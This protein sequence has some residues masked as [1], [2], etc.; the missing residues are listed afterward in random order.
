MTDGKTTPA[1]AREV[2]LEQAALAYAAA[3]KAVDGYAGEK[4]GP[5]YAEL[6]ATW[7]AATLEL[8]QASVRL[9][10]AKERGKTNAAIQPA[11]TG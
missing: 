1:T 11:K 8:D 6:I 9:S 4:R 7:R 5:I 3:K 2:S 10:R